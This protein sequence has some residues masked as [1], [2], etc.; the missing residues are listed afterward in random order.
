M[1]LAVLIYRYF[2]YGGQQ[3]D[4]L[5]IATEA[6]RRGHEVRV[7]CH[8][9]EGEV[10][11]GLRVESV[12]VKGLANH[13]RMVRFGRAAQTA[14]ETFAPDLVLGFVKLPGLD[15]YY[16]ADTCFADKAARKWGALMG[17][18]PRNRAYLALEKAVFDP[19]STTRILEI[20]VPER[21]RFIRHYQTPEARFHTLIPGISRTR[22]APDNHAE[23]RAASRAE[24][25]LADREVVLLALGSGFRTKGLDRS[26]GALAELRGK[27]V[28]AQ[29][30]VV[31]KDRADPFIKL[32]QRLGVVDRVRFLGGRDDVPSL[33]QAA[34]VLIHPAWRENTG[35]VLLEAMIAGL[36]VVATRTCGYSV[37]V[38]EAGMGAVVA[39]D[40]TPAQIAE[41][42]AD[43][44]RTPGEQWH[45]Q[46]R[47]FA[48]TANIYDM[49]A[50]TVDILESLAVER[51]GR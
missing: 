48:E 40:A 44:L 47:R 51:V 24:L 10:P 22:I 5:A 11:A 38:T 19:V 45:R 32:A 27:G 17:L 50:H 6:L 26:I 49:P 46:G 35:T 31:G 12:P 25:G 16:A 21:A 34:D 28:E 9:W 15:A 23:L 39:D 42:V 3:R 1:K 13:R 36:P 7:Y 37:Y 29:L 4:M 18:L 30:L 43:I 8:R 2:P 20:S 33:L 41:A 14:L